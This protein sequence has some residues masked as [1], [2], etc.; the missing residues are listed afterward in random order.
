MT[1]RSESGIGFVVRISM[2]RDD[3]SIAGRRAID[4]AL[5]A[6]KY[7]FIVSVPVRTELGCLFPAIS[8]PDEVSAGAPNAADNFPGAYG[9]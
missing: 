2:N 3:A 1:E 6:M 4:Y 9:L 5:K 7:V 8:F